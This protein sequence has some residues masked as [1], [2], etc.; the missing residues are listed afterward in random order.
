[1]RQQERQHGPAREEPNI[2]PP[3][4]ASRVPYCHT[5]LLDIRVAQFHEKIPFPNI[6]FILGNSSGGATLILF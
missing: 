3:Y 1:M 6:F 2:S 5:I 4:V